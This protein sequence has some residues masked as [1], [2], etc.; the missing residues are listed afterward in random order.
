LFEDINRKKKLKKRTGKL[1]T[2]K[3]NWKTYASY[4]I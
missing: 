1:K 3:K 2:E 4:I